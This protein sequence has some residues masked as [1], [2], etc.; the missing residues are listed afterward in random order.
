VQTCPPRRDGRLNGKRK[1]VD[2]CAVQVLK[3]KLCESLLSDCEVEIRRK[4]ASGP[5]PKLPQRSATL[6]HESQIEKA[7]LVEE[8]QRVILRDVDERS[9]AEHALPL[10]MTQQ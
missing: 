3:D 9:V 5:K 7:S 4:P 1:S 8:M 6:E 2:R 10:A